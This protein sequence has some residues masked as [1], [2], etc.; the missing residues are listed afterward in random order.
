MAKFNFYLDEKATIWYRTNF[1]VE[2]KTIE[3]A[4]ELAIKKHENGELEM[5]SWEPV[6]ET[7]E[8]ISLKENE[9][10]S[11]AEI[12]KDDGELIFQNGI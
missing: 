5:L 11:T 12:Y 3:E 4:K 10:Y 8:L 9:G 6:P 1:E 7:T 2:A